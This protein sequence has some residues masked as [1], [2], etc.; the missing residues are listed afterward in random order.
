MTFG[1]FLVGVRHSM[2]ISQV[3]LARKLK[4]SRSMICDIEKERVW[5]SPALAMKIAKTGK[6]Q[7]DM[8]IQYCIQ[9]QLKKAKI[10][11]KVNVE[12]A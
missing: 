3:G 1:T 4:V 8:A 2:G 11:M 12:A 10:K 9:D 7:K 5:V 6:F